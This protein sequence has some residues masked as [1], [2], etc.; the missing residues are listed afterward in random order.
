MFQSIL[1]KQKMHAS[2]ISLHLQEINSL[3][4]SKCTQI[5][6][7]YIMHANFEVYEV[8]VYF[9]EF[10]PNLMHFVLVFY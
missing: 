5:T 10:W 1:Y 2:N 3:H 8:R 9:L 7:M 6:Y 4:N